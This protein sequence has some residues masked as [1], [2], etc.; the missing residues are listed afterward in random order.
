MVIVGAFCLVMGGGAIYEM[1]KV[2]VRLDNGQQVPPVVATVNAPDEPIDFAT[3]YALQ[4]G[5]A[6]MIVGVEPHAR[7]T[8]AAVVHPVVTIHIDGDGV[9][10]LGMTNDAAWTEKLVG[11][12][13]S[14]NTQGVPNFDSMGNAPGVPVTLLVSTDL[15]NWDW[16]TTVNVETNA[17][18]VD[19]DR[20]YYDG[21]AFYRVEP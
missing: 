8:S 6:W 12:V 3:A 14:L 9:V 18:F 17:S 1:H 19:V 2:C 13:F 21:T 11:D 20:N 4:V 5:Y 15:V 10:T 16:L 7:K